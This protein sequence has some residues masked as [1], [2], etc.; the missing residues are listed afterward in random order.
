MWF[1]LANTK[2]ELLLYIPPLVLSH[3]FNLSLP[4]AQ[5]C[6]SVPH[7]G[8]YIRTLTCHYQSYTAASMHT[9]PYSWHVALIGHHWEHATALWLPQGWNC[10]SPSTCCAAITPFPLSLSH[11]C[12]LYSQGL[13]HCWV[14]PTHP[15][16]HWGK[17][18]TQ[19]SHPWGFCICLRLRHWHHCSR[20]YTC[21]SGSRHYSSSMSAK[22]QDL[23]FTATLS[24][25]MLDLVPRGIS[26]ITLLCHGPER[27]IQAVG[28]QKL[29][30]QGPR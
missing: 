4:L 19:T 20:K 17:P 6:H 11:C 12:M 16:C 18:Q 15:T 28:L 13:Y 3:S 23:S 5:C 29:H 2:A 7:P 24:A 9:T 21:T 27:R 30:C 8:S 14:L 26:S 25:S 1:W 22:S 10:E